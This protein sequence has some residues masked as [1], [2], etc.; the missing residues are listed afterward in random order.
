LSDDQVTK[1]TET[2]YVHRAAD[3]RAWLRTN[4]K[5]SREIWL[6]YYRKETGK[7]RIS[8]ND[9]STRRSASGGSTARRRS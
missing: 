7:P 5:T 9:A 2:L 3:W 8:Y 4:H 6:V 1:V